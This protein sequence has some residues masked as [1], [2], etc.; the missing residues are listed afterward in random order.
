[1]KILGKSV[2][3]EFLHFYEDLQPRL[4]MQIKFEVIRP[5]R[6]G[7][8]FGAYDD[9]A[10][11]VMLRADLPRPAFEHTAAHELLHVLQAKEGW[12]KASR[13]ATLSEDCI[14]EEVA[15]LIASLVLDLDVEE[16]L[17]KLGF[18]RSYSDNVRYKQKLKALQGK[19]VPRLGSPGWCMWA[20]HYA[21]ASQTLSASRLRK[22]ETLHS[23]LAPNI[24]EKGKELVAMLN[25]HGWKSPDQALRSMVAIRDSLGLT[26][27][28]VLITDRRTGIDY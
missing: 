26:K 5:F 23:A 14:E 13:G 21:I 24:A 4:G 3:Q 28:R 9:S 22:L 8:V 12:P 11:R 18:D 7:Y 20:I 2:S 16:Q 25:R 6:I 1:M 15:G 17:R 27:E 19:N 10:G